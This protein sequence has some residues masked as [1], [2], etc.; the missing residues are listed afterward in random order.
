MSFRLF[1]YYTALCGGWAALGGWGLSR[2]FEG[3]VMAAAMQG[4]M[5]G[6][7]VALGVGLMD[8]LGAGSAQGGKPMVRCLV[9]VAVGAIGGF[10][11]GLL[12]QLLANTTDSETTQGTLRTIGWTLTGLLVG[13]SVGVYDLLARLT[14]GENTG[15]ARKKLLNGLIGG[16]VGGM[17]GSV[18]LLMLKGALDNLFV[19][20]PNALTPSAVGFVVLGLC[21]G[22]FIG[23]AQVILKQAWIKVERGFKPGREMILTKPET[24]IGRAEGCDVGLYGDRAVERTHAKIIH[25]AH[26]YLIADAS[27]P[28]GTYVNGQ[29][30]A[31]PV[32][33]KSGDMI[34]V[35]DCILRFEERGRSRN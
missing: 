9:C 14:R 18:F 15:G 4:M 23:L 6:L 31:G 3:G 13:A 26:E 25:R 30:I 5:L 17:F 16:A 11:G 29:R 10:L 20:K 2:L 27:T 22:L 12:G 7:L 19:N 8:V 33:L 35:G 24:I 1:I 21:I 34:R 28:R 32:P